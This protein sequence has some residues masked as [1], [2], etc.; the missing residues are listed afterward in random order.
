VL[1]VRFFDNE[2]G[3]GFLINQPGLQPLIYLNRTLLGEDSNDALY[4]KIYD[5]LVEHY[6][7]LNFWELIMP[8]CTYYEELTIQEVPGSEIIILGRFER[9]QMPCPTCESRMYGY[10]LIGREA[11]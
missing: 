5:R 4:R 2:T 6:N 8:F 11:G 9:V 1:E 7:S 3:Y 10:R